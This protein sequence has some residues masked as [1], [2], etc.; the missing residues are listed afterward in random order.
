MGR[1]RR[2]AWV[3]RVVLSCCGWCCLGCTLGP[4]LCRWSVGLDSVAASVCPRLARG[5]S[6][7]KKGGLEPHASRWRTPRF[8]RRSFHKSRVPPFI[9]FPPAFPRCPRFSPFPPGALA[10]MSPGICP[11]PA[12]PKY[13]P[14]RPFPGKFPPPGIPAGPTGGTPHFPPGA[15]RPTRE[16]N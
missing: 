1:V 2:D 7:H 9:P 12:E 14:G 11:N 5:W 8:S 6:S 13:A 4:R 16:W 3:V 15:R 10:L